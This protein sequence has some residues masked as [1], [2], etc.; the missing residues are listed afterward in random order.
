[1]YIIKY[2]INW[3]YYNSIQIELDKDKG[4]L[5]SFQVQFLNRLT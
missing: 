4:I 2:C 5:Y 3:H 1:M